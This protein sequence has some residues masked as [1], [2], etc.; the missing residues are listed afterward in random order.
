MIESE[1]RNAVEPHAM[2]EH[3]HTNGKPS[4]RKLRLFAVACSRR[5]WILIDN[6]GR[7]AVDAAEE[8]ADGRLGSDELRAARL[9]CQGTG[10]QA[11][12]YA[13]AT[14]P[15]IAARNAARSAQAGAATL[16]TEAEELLAQADLVRE[17]FDN[18][19]QRYPDEQSWLTPCV[20]GLAQAIYDDRAFD[21]I[22]DLADALERA[23]CENDKILN[24]CRGPMPHV[25]GCWVIDLMLGKE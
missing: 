3:L 18:P 13:A 15:F 11:S 4:D 21:R 16:G 12:W 22:P 8:C 20:V 1:W 2:L 9:A 7:A 25:R 19:F 17:I 24:H 10:G 14:S 23:G 5:I 6:L